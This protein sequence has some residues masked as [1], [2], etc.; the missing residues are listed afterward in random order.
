MWVEPQFLEFD[1]DSKSD[2]KSESNS[3][4][5]SNTKSES[6]PNSKSDSDPNVDTDHDSCRADSEQYEHVGQFYESSQR[7]FGRK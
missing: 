1:L 4:S 2:F 6:G 7:K 3:K 5:Q